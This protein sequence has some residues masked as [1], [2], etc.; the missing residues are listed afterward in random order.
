MELK[1]LYKQVQFLE[2][3]K[4]LLKEQLNNFKTV[5]F[6]YLEKVNTATWHWL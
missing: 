2:N 1:Y 6:S 4:L 5:K 3:E